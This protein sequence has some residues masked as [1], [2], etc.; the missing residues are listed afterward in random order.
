[1]KLKLFS[2]IELLKA[3]SG[4]LPAHLVDMVN[5]GTAHWV[6]VKEGPLQGRHLLISGK[7]PAE[8][9]QSAGRILAGQGIPP[10]VIQKIT[11]A[12]HAHELP[13]AQKENDS[14]GYPTIER[15]VQIPE[16]IKREVPRAGTYKIVSVGRKWIK[17]QPEGSGYAVDLAITP[18]TE[19]LKPGE[20]ATMMVHSHTERSKYGAKTTVYPASKESTEEA[21]AK[22]QSAETDRWLGYVLDAADKGY[23]YDKGL[24]KL[25]ELGSLDNP[26][27]KSRIEA[28]KAKINLSKIHQWLGYVKDAAGEGRVYDKGVRTLKN[29][30]IDAYPE[31]KAKM[32]LSVEQGLQAQ[33]KKETERQTR[34]SKR[35]MYALDDSPPVGVPTKYRDG[36]VVFTS[37]GKT[38]RADE[39]TS[40]IGGP[41]G[42]EGDKVAYFYY[43]DATPEEVKQYERSN[44]EKQNRAAK[45]DAIKTTVSNVRKQITTDGERPE[46]AN[47]EGE[48][49][50]DTMNI[51]GGGDKFVVGDKYIWYIRN[52]GADGDSWAGNNVRTGGAGAIGWRIPYDKKTA[53]DILSAHAEYKKTVA[54]KSMRVYSAT[55]LLKAR[56]VKYIR[57]DG[58]PGSYKYVY[59]EPSAD[60]SHST[61]GES[62]SAA[63]GAEFSPEET[64]A[65]SV[66]KG[67][68]YRFN[69]EKTAVNVVHNAKSPS[70]AFRI[71]ADR[72]WVTTPADGTRLERAGYEEVNT[73]AMRDRT[74][75][76]RNDDDGRGLISKFVDYLKNQ[77]EYKIGDKVDEDE[78]QRGIKVEMEHTDSRKIAK[79][80]ALDHLKESPTYYRDLSKMEA[81]ERGKRKGAKERQK[82]RV[83]SATQILLEKAAHKLAYRTEFQGLPI[84]IENARGSVRHWYDPAKDEHGTTKMLYPYGYIRLTE[85][86]DGDAVDCYIG[87]DK[88]SRRVFVVHQNNPRTGEYDEDKCMLGFESAQQAKRAYLAHYNDPKFFGGM[89][90]WDVHDFVD[91]IKRKRKHG[92]LTTEKAI[93]ML[94]TEILLAKAL[95][96]AMAKMVKNGAA[97][98][99]TVKEGPLEGR[100]DERPSETWG[101]NDPLS[102][103]W[104]KVN[105]RE[106]QLVNE[107][108]ARMK[109]HGSSK[110]ILKQNP[111]GG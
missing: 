14:Q 7:R 64:R 13:H 32:D 15:N 28:A 6:T 41:I 39:D 77:G 46:K 70:R 75:K 63:K 107:L 10:H 96:P 21:S 76:S 34:I 73:G 66:V 25:K 47:P 86:P 85:A 5:R 91:H 111:F 29:L 26:E 94:P 50:F 48:A 44:E 98:W 106:R 74:Q 43:R 11:G 55:E 81:N 68:V 69:T 53:E 71:G 82:S 59:K 100:G 8:G 89:S 65:K 27:V 99:V 2:A 54:E 103:E 72:I 23:L 79:Q 95:S 45:I 19:K 37:V 36:V 51:Y 9:I 88:D 101:K 24:A 61:D 92:M 52:N 17:A 31:L 110:K 84:S 57:R 22:K 90:V 87:P 35:H 38:F 97:H 78:L 4:K 105:N 93:R 80:I 62:H 49:V 42:R 109:Y 102:M 56:S 83:L 18:E 33:K 20:K 67:T 1:M 30:G 12:T 104:K 16:H 40:S 3:K 58:A 108:E 60:H